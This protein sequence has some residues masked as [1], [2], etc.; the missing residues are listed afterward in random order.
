MEY[1]KA[2]KI[3]QALRKS[4]ANDLFVKRDRFKDSKDLEAAIKIVEKRD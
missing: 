3:E 1:S 2:H 4:I